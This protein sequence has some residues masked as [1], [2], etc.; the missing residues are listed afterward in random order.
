MDFGVDL[1]GRSAL[2]T[3]GSRG[4]GR[5]ITLAL[6]GCGAAVA[7]NYVAREAEAEAVVE[8]IRSAGGR[9]TAVR[10]DVSVAAEVAAL[11]GQV[12]RDLGP[13][14]ILVNNAGIALADA[15]EEAFDRTLATNLKSAW[16]C[17]E[18]FLPG[19]R[20]R[21]WGRIVNMSSIA[22]RGAGAIGVAYN[23]S[24]AGLEGLTRGYA[25]RAACDGVTVNA[26]APGPTDTEMG[27]P[28]AAAGVVARIPMGRMGRTEDVAQA[29]ILVV[30]NDF[31]TGQTIAVNGGL[32]LL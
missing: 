21:R 10:A 18:A 24:K 7:V 11:A 17:T 5:A 25:A 4:I 2:V 28:L 22:A 29:T 6:A 23:A 12:V 27:A 19:M 15:D 30:A 13:V 31:M 8:R 14:D 16:L 1:S 32:A 9:A 26:I 20:A 3:G